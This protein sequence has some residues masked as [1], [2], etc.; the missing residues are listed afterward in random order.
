MQKSCTRPL[1]EHVYR[2]NEEDIKY[3]LNSLDIMIEV[4]TTRFKPATFSFKKTFQ[5]KHVWVNLINIR[6]L[7]L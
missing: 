3:F 7:G 6:L 1:D 5:D 4:W 2:F